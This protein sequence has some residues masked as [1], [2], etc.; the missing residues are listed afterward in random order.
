MAKTKIKFKLNNREIRTDYINLTVFLSFITLCI[1]QTFHVPSII[2]FL[3]D[4]PIVLMVLQNIRGFLNTLI[5]KP[6]ALMTFTLLVALIAMILGGII[7]AVLIGNAV[8]GIYKYFRGFVFFYCVLAFV[9]LKS[10]GQTLEMINVIFWINIILTMVEFFLLGIDQDLLGG[11]FGLVVG[12]NQYT[13]MFFLIVSVY[14]IEKIV[15]RDTD[16][17]KYRM[18]LVVSGL[19]LVVAALAEMKYFFAEFIVLFVIAYLCLPKKIKSLIGVVLVLVCVIACYNI[20]IRNFPEFANLAYELKQ[21]GFA[22]LADLQRHYSTDYDIG[23]AVV[24]SYSNR[25]LL[26]KSINQWFGMGIGSVSSSGIVDNSF[27]LKNQA[28][29]YDQFYTAYLYNEQGGI[30]FVLYCLIYLELLIIGIRAVWCQKTRKYGT[31]LIML[32]VGC[33]MIFAYNMALYSQLSFIMFWAL[34]VLVKKSAQCFI[35]VD[36]KTS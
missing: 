16:Q 32:V 31:M 25:Y 17:K 26:P 34:A 4:V 30:G 27:W 28:T 18:I 20:L 13:N 35:N 23:R 10:I 7:N 12:V 1:A 14:C 22:R 24:F 36:L 8:Y 9:D 21:G 3:I 33:I 5:W 11:V 6:V 29:H 2:Y 19:M 15:K